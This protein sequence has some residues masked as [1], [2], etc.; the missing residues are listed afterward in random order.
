[1]VRH[2][3]SLQFIVYQMARPVSYLRIHHDDKW[4]YDWLLPAALTALTVAFLAAFSNLHAV[5]GEDALLERI[6]GFVENLP[7]FFIAALAAVATFNKHDIDQ[8][9]NNPPK[10][11]I[12]YQGTR[13]MVEM[14][15]RRFLCVLFSYL[16][17]ASIFIVICFYLGRTVGESN[18][19]PSAVIWTATATYLF[20][21][22]QMIVAT[23]L[24]LY[25]LGERLHTPDS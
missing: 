9:M 7:G 13:I 23:L 4:I 19:L 17:A 16:T 25:Y 21:F 1:M 10:V 11:S 15:R 24:G 6:T 3:K 2:L 22:W 8:L 18:D 5:V 14:T 12:M 20:V